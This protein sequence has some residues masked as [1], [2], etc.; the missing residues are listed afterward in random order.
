MAESYKFPDEKETEDSDFE[1][2]TEEGDIELE[3]VDDTPEQD[4]GRK[5][6]DREVADPTDEEIAE[7]SEKVQKR[8]K[9]L[10]HARH[11]ERRAKE[12]AT[13][14]R[15]EAIRVAQQ[16]I[17]ENKA[18]RQNVNSSQNTAVESMKA[19]AESALVMARKKLKEAQENYDTDAIIEAQEELAAARY[20]FEKLKDYKTAP[21]QERDEEVYNQTT[22]PQ[23]PLPDQ[24]AMSWQ[25]QN[26]WFGKDDEMTSLAL[27][28]HKKLVESGVDPR[29]DEYYERVDARMREV[30]PSFFGETKKEQPSKRSANVVAAVTRSANG[31]TKVKL[32]KTQEALARKF[33][34]TNEQYAR[35][36]LKLTS[37]S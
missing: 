35:E 25:Q 30:F 24:K 22:T 26:Q 27:A 14:E 8:M 28:V 6:L 1:V 11:D 15:E 19:Q 23:A 5:P 32:T 13:R 10:T 29:S 18:L 2:E 4:R 9:E 7:Y 33:N 3:V 37:E 21:L 31:K 20:R 36:V 17:E 16:L 34:L 12:A